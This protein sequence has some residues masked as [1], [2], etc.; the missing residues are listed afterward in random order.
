MKIA[1]QHLLRFLPEKPSLSDISDSLYQLGHE[2][3]IENEI[4]NFEFTPNRGDCLSLLGL[5]RDLNSF[6]KTNLD[7]KYYKKNLPDLDINFYNKAQEK[8]PKISFLNIEIRGDIS[9]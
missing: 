5:S 1:Y 4:L 3:E 9:G 7:L 2:H 8:C 6:F